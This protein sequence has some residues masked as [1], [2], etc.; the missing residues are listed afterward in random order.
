MAVCTKSY[1]V[2]FMRLGPWALPRDNEDNDDNDN[3]EKI[4][5]MTNPCSIIAPRE[6]HN[7]FIPHS[8]KK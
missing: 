2:H 5:I 7:P 1:Y 6:F 4:S 8:D 3:N